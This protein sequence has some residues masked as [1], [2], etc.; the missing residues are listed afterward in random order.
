MGDK[1]LREDFGDLR[2]TVN[3]F[4]AL[5]TQWNEAHDKHSREV[6]EGI[7]DRTSKLFD[8]QEKMLE[9]F[10][11]LPC[12]EH[13]TRMESIKQVANAKI[14]SVEKRVKW[15]WGLLGGGTAMIVIGFFIKLFLNSLSIPVA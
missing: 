4:C 1:T 14:V 9:K 11:E 10:G 13:D 15:L 8:M 6:L 12:R 3:T 5:Q 2:A 7:K